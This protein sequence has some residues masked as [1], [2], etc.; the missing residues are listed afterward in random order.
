LVVSII[1]VKFASH[2]LN[3]NYLKYITTINQTRGEKHFRRMTLEELVETIRSEKYEKQISELRQYYS[4][5]H[6]YTDDD[7]KIQGANDSH[8]TTA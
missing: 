3:Y 1:F 6:A 7:G 4:A 2:F 8:R 5:L